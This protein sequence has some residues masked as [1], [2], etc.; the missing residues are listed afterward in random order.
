MKKI[1]LALSTLYADLTQ[2]VHSRPVRPGSTFTMKVKGRDYVYVKRQV[3]RV[4]RNDY[5]GPAD[6]AETQAAVELIKGVQEQAQQDKKTIS[7]LKRAG[8]PAPTPQLGRVLDALSDAGVFK[9]ATLIGTAAYQ[10]YPPLVAHVLPRPTLM[11]ADA[12]LATA[13]LAITTL[14]ENETILDVLKRAEP[15]FAPVPALSPTAP[16]SAFRAADGFMVDLVTQQ[17]TR[18]DANPLRLKGGGAGATPLQF[19]RWLIAEP[20]AA[21]ALYGS[22]VAV[23]VPQPARFAVHKLILAQERRQN[24]RPKR[25]K[26]LLQAGA[27]IEALRESDPYALSDAF[28]SARGQGGRWSSRIGRSLAEL[29]L[30]L[31]D[32]A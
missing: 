9:E 24:E 13:R 28:D 26:D 19:V 29:E 11:T 4:R 14:A 15:S 7:L 25:Q 12:D 5:L 22:G 23:S 32:V 2:R 21:I 27:L 3:G 6:E 16:P 18:H 17:R 20:V 10:C 1:G 30:T 8:V 31:E